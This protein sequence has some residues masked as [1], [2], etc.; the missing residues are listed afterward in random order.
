MLA[1]SCAGLVT[2]V[3][4][5]GPVKVRPLIVSWCGED[6]VLLAEGFGASR[7]RHGVDMLILV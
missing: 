1:A 7:P 6:L 5:R 2:A 4:G 3:G